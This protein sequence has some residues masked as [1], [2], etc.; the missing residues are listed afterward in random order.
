MSRELAAVSSGTQSSSP[1]R[2]QPRISRMLGIAA[3]W[4]ACFVA[5]GWAL[6][7][8]P[9]LWFAA[10]RALL[11]GAALLVVA[12]IRG[13]GWRVDRRA[14]PL[15]GVLALFNVTIAF[16]AMFAAAEGV[17][18][19]IASILANAQPLFI[20]LPAWWMYRERPSEQSVLGLVI[21]FSGLTLIVGADY[22]SG[23]LLA[24]LAAGGIT[25]GT[26][27]TRQLHLQDLLAPIGWHF[28]V[29]AGVLMIVAGVVEGPPAIQ[30]TFRLV[31]SLTFL[32]LF[33]TA[34]AFVVWFDESRRAPLVSVTA[35]VFLVP[36]FG[37]GFGLLLGESLSGW[38]GLGVGLA[39]AGLV[40][41]LRGNAQDRAPSQVPPDETEES[42]DDRG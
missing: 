3:V 24:L 8:A 25:V 12:A 4:G 18:T 19:G 7:D 10:L 28:I 32:S 14:F 5:I 1:V 38:Q 20:I 31:V 30:W 9:A 42:Y 16:G 6:D 23:V 27:L 34:W 36:V 22:G 37:L 41:V 29:G 21:A 40:T 39:L 33:G 11:S 35:W 2:A 17:A 15:L 13:Q 26:L